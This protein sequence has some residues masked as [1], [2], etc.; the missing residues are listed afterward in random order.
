MATRLY[1]FGY[2]H[3]DALHPPTGLVIDV[4]RHFTR[5]P[6]QNI[7]LRKLRGTDDP[8]AAYIR[9][10]PGFDLAYAGLKQAVTGHNGPVFLGC[11]GGHHR[12]V[13]LAARLGEELNV[14]VEHLDIDK[15]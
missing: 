11:T 1:S 13:Y 2:R 8:V 6:F 4:R 5:N 9:D 7:R 3:G 15:R 10:S 12:S 14:P